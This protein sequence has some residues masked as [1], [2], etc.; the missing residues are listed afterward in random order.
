MAVKI[1]E[2]YSGTRSGVYMYGTKSYDA[3]G[4]YYPVIHGYS[5]EAT[6]WNRWFVYEN[7]KVEEQ[8]SIENI[9][10]YINSTES[11]GYAA[12][13][14]EAEEKAKQEAKAK[15]EAKAQ[16]EQQVS[17]KFNNEFSGDDYTI[18]YPSNYKVEKD[19]EGFDVFTEPNS[20]ANISITTAVEHGEVK[21]ITKSDMEQ[22][23]GETFSKFRKL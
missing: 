23:L 6:Y 13:Q 10:G 14:Q 17:D 2:A 18:R 22:M 1:V 11:E 3:D 12:K 7:G 8:S 20:G 16:A 21:G 15:E 5:Y 4:N 19:V 9:E